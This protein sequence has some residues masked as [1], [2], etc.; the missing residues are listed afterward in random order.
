M[1]PLLFFGFAFDG[2]VASS[3]PVLPTTQKDAEA[4]EAVMRPAGLWLAR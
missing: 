3:N 4:H 1:L 2:L